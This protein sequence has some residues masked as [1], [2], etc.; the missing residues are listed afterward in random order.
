M[1]FD[2]TQDDFNYIFTS[3]DDAVCVMNSKGVLVSANASAQKLFGINQDNLSKEKI[4][5]Y[6][7]YTP[8]ND[9][10][11]Q[12][13]IDASNQKLRN[14]QG[15]VDYENEAGKVFK[16][17]VS[18]SATRAADG[19]VLYIIIISDLTEFIRVNMAFERYTSRE[20]ADYV[21]HNPNGELLGG[22]QCECSILMSDLRGFTALSTKLSPADLIIVLNHYF[23]N[24]VEVIE[25]NGGSV[26]EF[27]GDGIFVIFGAPKEDKDHALHSV[28][29]AV[30]MQ[31]AMEAV[32][33][34]NEENNYPALEM[35]IGINSGKVV[36]GNIGSLKKTKYGCM[37]ENVNLAGRV[38]TYTVGGQ[39]YI[40]EHTRNGITERL[41]IA[42][43]DSFMP[44]G[45]KEPLKI[46]E[47]QGVGQLQIN[48][49]NSEINWE[50]T[51]Q[52]K[53]VVFYALEGK[54]V[55]GDKNKG[56]IKALSEDRRFGLLETGVKLSD[57]QN[58]M[59]DIGG[60]LYA[61]VIDVSEGKYTICF[62]AKPDVFKA[63]EESVFNV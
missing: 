1:S 29:C 59:L 33:K 57:K 50:N 7:P 52:N 17:R 37:G 48:V 12:M 58:I 20:I 42:S 41:D 49:A 14:H 19:E 38:E 21:L 56:S 35:G 18:M 22:K 4:W 43:E 24:M 3:M 61:K 25:K 63:W 62:T 30:E 53:E 11:I 27:L 46:Y 54:S 13:F 39:I 16:L 55:G 32:N 40:S 6:I 36:V 28:R 44:K 60:D 10:L 8:K 34:W 51:K 47:I 5:K 45:G 9:D 31:N 23:E 26:I 2:L 15:Y